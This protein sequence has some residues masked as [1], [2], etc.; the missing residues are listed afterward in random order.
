MM[1]Y[2]LLVLDEPSD[3]TKW[4]MIALGAFV[5]LY[6][7]VLRPMMRGTKDPLAAPR[8][9]GM[10]SLSSQR[11]VERDMRNLLVEYEQMIRNMTAGL[12][13]RAVRLEWLIKQADEKLAALQAAAAAPAGD[14]TPQRD[15]SES[16]RRGVPGPTPPDLSG[17]DPRHAEIYALGDQGLPANDIARKLGRP[18]GE[19]ELILAL[20]SGRE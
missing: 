17:P 2:P 9:A 13:A 15:A 11:A 5:L 8:G 20:R 3:T 10:A 6:L 12:D 7:A 1:D 19:I 14:P 16:A 4:V 18:S